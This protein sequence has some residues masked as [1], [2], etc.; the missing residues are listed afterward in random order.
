MSERMALQ[1]IYGSFVPQT[2]RVF[3][4][5]SFAT[6]P[7]GNQIDIKYDPEL[8]LI[9]S[10]DIGAATFAALLVQQH[11]IDDEVRYVIVGDVCSSGNIDVIFDKIKTSYGKN[12]ARIIA[13]TDLNHRSST[14]ASTVNFFLKKNF[15]GAII[16]GLNHT[17]EK[18]IMNRYNRALFG[19][20]SSDGNRRLLLSKSLKHLG[21]DTTRR[22]IVATMSDFC[23][24]H[25]DKMDRGTTTVPR[26]V[27]YSHIADCLLN[28]S[29]KFWPAI[30][31]PQ[32]HFAK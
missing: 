28:M 24:P 32:E 11:T 6:Y 1:E 29:I 17:N 15:P 31:A 26:N 13:G 25:N 7:N 19:I 27:K 16:S 30:A 2:G 21:K 20:N 14:D 5:F 4:N 23:W 9:M 22:G 8:P 3:D 18:P 12:P 10:I